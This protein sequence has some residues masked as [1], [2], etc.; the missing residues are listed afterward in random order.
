M[1]IGLLSH[2][3]EPCFV[4][5]WWYIL[6]IRVNWAKF[7]MNCWY[8]FTTLLL[9]VVYLHVTMLD[10]DVHSRWKACCSM[11]LCLFCCWMITHP[12]WCLPGSIELCLSWMVMH[13]DGSYPNR[14]M[15]AMQA[16]K[17]LRNQRDEL[18]LG[19]PTIFKSLKK[20]RNSPKRFPQ[21]SKPLVRCS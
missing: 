7:P 18:A 9:L 20:F 3:V 1:F 13:V 11:Q 15:M 17:A 6:T 8:C 5:E 14:Q 4:D 2:A 21:C 12:C 19:P 16:L 10:D